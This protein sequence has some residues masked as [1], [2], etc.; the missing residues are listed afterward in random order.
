MKSFN[1][2]KRAAKNIPSDAAA[3][4]KIALLGDTATQLMKTALLGCL[5]SDGVKADI[6]EAE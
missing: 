3:D 5:Y 6:Y 4:V 2:L 1:E